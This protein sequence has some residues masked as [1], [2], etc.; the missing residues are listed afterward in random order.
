MDDQL[1]GSVMAQDQDGD[2]GIAD[3]LESFDNN[4]APLV[5]VS[6]TVLSDRKRTQITKIHTIRVIGYHVYETFSTGNAKS[7][8][9]DQKALRDK[10][11]T[12]KDYKIEV[13]DSEG[14]VV[15][16]F[17]NCKLIDIVFEEGS[18]THYG[19]FVASFES[20]QLASDKIESLQYTLDF[21]DNPDMGYVDSNGGIVTASYITASEKI[22][23]TGKNIDDVISS[24]KSNHML[25]DGDNVRIAGDGRLFQVRNLRSSSNGTVVTEGTVST[26]QTMV[27]IPSNLN[28]D[29]VCGINIEVSRTYNQGPATITL[30]GTALNC[31]S[32]STPYS[33]FK[34]F[35]DN[36][37]L[38]AKNFDGLMPR[39]YVRDVRQGGSLSNTNRDQ[40]GSEIGR[41]IG[42]DNQTGMINFT[43]V[44]EICK[45]YFVSNA[46]YERITEN[47]Q[48]STP[49][50]AI[51]PVIG[52]TNGPVLQSTYS[53]TENTKEVNIEVVFAEGHDNY[54][55]RE[56][57]DNLIVSYVPTG[58]VAVVG[59]V[60]ESY[61]PTER[62]Y[63][64]T[65]SWIYSDAIFEAHNMKFDENGG[66]G[67]I[68]VDT[69]I[70]S[71]AEFD[72][73]YE[74][75]KWEMD[76]DRNKGFGG[77][78]ND[79]FSVSGTGKKATIT[80]D[81]ELDFESR[82][83]Y[84]IRVRCKVKLKPITTPPEERFLHLTL[85]IFPDDIEERQNEESVEDIILITNTT[86]YTPAPKNM[87]IGVL[88]L[89]QDPDE[90]HGKT[91]SLDGGVEY[92]VVGSNTF[93]TIGNK[94]VTGEEYD[95]DANTEE[96]VTVKAIAPDGTTYQRDITITV[97]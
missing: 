90:R 81:E 39:E 89:Q 62:K 24:V 5:G 40:K 97:L 59:D 7:I 38:Y 96:S 88:H 56:S 58:N 77:Y 55:E 73:R 76:T 33:S 26:E 31:S 51:I 61:N 9:D 47:I 41:D 79:L 94:L 20:T 29:L 30:S 10:F 69:N 71:E 14:T 25:T 3:V 12:K 48:R 19:K 43:Y 23:A 37:F 83:S 28:Q 75:V 16:T 84:V 64:L 74:V 21:T 86:M 78:D 42:I 63:T 65:M 92:F 8:L 4:P 72:Q 66:T 53:R 52:K 91:R 54:T 68:R 18:Y 70:M 36:I 17:A 22:V 2:P 82:D 35:E 87:I 50:F 85:R 80:A 11:T 44:Y 13:K 32:G 27:L 34:S 46:V 6:T 67:Q 49:T 15:C 1:F 45:S 60:Q 95:G 93:K 57:V